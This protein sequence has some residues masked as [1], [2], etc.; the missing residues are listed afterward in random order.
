MLN[1]YSKTVDGM[2]IGLR[3]VLSG[4]VCNVNYQCPHPS[5]CPLYFQALKF[6]IDFN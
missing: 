2:E 1:F 4:G 6:I 3:M 5:V